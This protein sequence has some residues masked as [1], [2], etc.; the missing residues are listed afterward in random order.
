MHSHNFLLASLSVHA[1]TTVVMAL[2]PTF[3]PFP[4]GVT[5]ALMGAIIFRS[6]LVTELVTFTVGALGYVSFLTLHEAVL[7]CF[8]R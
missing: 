3:E 4:R 8:K 7:R 5:V 1:V 2:L 6:A